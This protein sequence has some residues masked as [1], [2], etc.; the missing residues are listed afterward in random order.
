MRRPAVLT[1]DWWTDA[2][3]SQRYSTVN[4][5][6]ASVLFQSYGTPSAEKILPTM[7]G[8]AE[9]AYSSSAVVYG[10]TAARGMLFSEAELRWQSLADRHLFGTPDLALLERPWPNGTTGELL[11]RMELDASLAGNAFVRKVNDEQLERLRPDRVTI[12]SEVRTDALGRDYREVVGFMH[13][14]LDDPDREVAFYA[15]DEVAHWAPSP[16]PM[17]SFRGMSWLTPVV[18]EVE[19]DSA[20]TDFKVRYLEHNATPNLLVRYDRQLKPETVHAITDRLSAVFGGPANAGKTLVL[21]QGADATVIGNTMEQMNFATVQAAGENRIAVAAGVP[22]IVAGLKEGLS[23]ATYSNYEQAMRRFADITMRPLWR[24]ACAA[25]AT[26]VVAPA[27]ARLWYDTSAIAALRQGEKERA[28]TVLV[29][30]TA[31]ETLLRAGYR[32][33][34]VAAAI[35][36][37]DLS[38]LTHSGLFSSQLMPPG[39]TATPAP[40]TTTDPAQG[41]TE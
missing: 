34:N 29:K 41:G 17:A 3:V 25:L 31:A 12:I 27:G 7:R 11:A 2:P 15:V 36:S 5:S 18:R 6:G 37:G 38:L 13:D 24:S 21:D 32:P 9:Q 1:R 16:D 8:L 10:L 23:A 20:M 35:E 33:D 22:G 30:A 4:P 40:T 19:A 28:D 39:T 14:P 26:L